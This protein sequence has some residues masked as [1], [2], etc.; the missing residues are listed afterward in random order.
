VFVE[1]ELGSASEEAK[2]KTELRQH[3]PR[4]P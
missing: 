4:H 1:E 3:H 2:M